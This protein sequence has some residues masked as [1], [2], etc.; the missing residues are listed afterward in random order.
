[1]Y[2]GA[3]EHQ[4]RQSPPRLTS[5]RRRAEPAEDAGVAVDLSRSSSASAQWATTSAPLPARSRATPSQSR[6]P[7]ACT[8]MGPPP[9]GQQISGLPYQPAR[10]R[11]T[12]S[13]RKRASDRPGSDTPRPLSVV[14]HDSAVRCSPGALLLPR[15]SS[16]GPPDRVPRC[17]DSWASWLPRR[18]G[19]HVARADLRK[20]ARS[21]DVWLRTSLSELST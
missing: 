7:S 19:G 21:C 5:R 17:P 9:A 1:V 10:A 14:G 4:H 13:P 20:N 16:P 18:R 15:C 2:S 11:A 8:V 6:T 12:W 3:K